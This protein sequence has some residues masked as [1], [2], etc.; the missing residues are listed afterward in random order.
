MGVITSLS[1]QNLHPIYTQKP[2]KSIEKYPK[3]NLFG[4]FRV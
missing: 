2:S 4:E 1:W 3:K